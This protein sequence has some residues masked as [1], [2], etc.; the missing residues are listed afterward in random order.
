MIAISI[1]ALKQWLLG[2]SVRGLVPLGTPR[3]MVGLTVFLVEER[4]EI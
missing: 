2:G 4:K 3:I 1:L